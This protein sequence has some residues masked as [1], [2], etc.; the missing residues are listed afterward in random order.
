MESRPGWKTTEFWV[1]LATTAVAL[2]A[3]LFGLGQQQSA[4]LSNAVQGA[5][6]AVAG[7]VAQAVVAYRYIMAREIVKLASQPEPEKTE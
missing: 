6:A 1:T 2:L 4:E 5:V 3:V 7:L